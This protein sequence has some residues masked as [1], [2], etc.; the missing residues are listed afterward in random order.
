MKCIYSFYYE[1]MFKLFN[2]TLS[3]TYYPFPSSG[4]I[5]KCPTSTASE[6]TPGYHRTNPDPAALPA[7]IKIKSEAPLA[8]AATF[9][10]PHVCPP[11]ELKWHQQSM[12]THKDRSRPRE[13]ICST[14]LHPPTLSTPQRAQN[15]RLQLL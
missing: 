4:I 15:Y 6:I 10:R 2:S 5:G 1:T 12:P 3:P 13:N 11:K 9:P 7:K 8:P 14:Y